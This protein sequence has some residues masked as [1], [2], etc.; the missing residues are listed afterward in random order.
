MGRRRRSGLFRKVELWLRMK[1]QQHRY[2]HIFLG[3]VNMR[4]QPP[5]GTGFHHRFQGRN[6]DGAR[7]KLGPDGKELISDRNV[8]CEGRGSR[9]RRQLAREAG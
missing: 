2:R 3:D 5:R 8:P 1:T 7:V 9:S 4:S 6:P